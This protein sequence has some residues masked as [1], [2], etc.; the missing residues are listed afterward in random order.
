MASGQ[1]SVM[2][3]RDRLRLTTDHYSR[4]LPPPISKIDPVTYDAA[5]DSSQRTASAISFGW[6][7][8]FMGI[9]PMSR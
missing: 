1:F 9:V 6:P 5:G 7:A 3:C 8:R 2:Q 4:Y